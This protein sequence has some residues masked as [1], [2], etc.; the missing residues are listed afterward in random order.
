MGCSVGFGTAGAGIGA[1]G[2]EEG[3]EL[4]AVRFAVD[5]ILGVVGRGG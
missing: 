2:E 5:G 3:E 1:G 4:D